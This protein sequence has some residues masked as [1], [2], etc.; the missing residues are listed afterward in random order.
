MFGSC[1]FNLVLYWVSRK[2]RKNLKKSFDGGRQDP[3]G[4]SC[5]QIFLN[6]N[7]N[8]YLLKSGCVCVMY[9]KLS[10][11]MYMRRKG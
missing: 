8:V 1:I 2:Y 9:V 7:R 4:I 10:Y 5:Y 6:F 3:S 11:S